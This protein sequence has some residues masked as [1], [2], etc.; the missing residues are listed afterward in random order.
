M[1]VKEAL[2]GQY[3]HDRHSTV[4]GIGVLVSDEHSD[5]KLLAEAAIMT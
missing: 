3:R 2:K 5:W 1:P 4:H